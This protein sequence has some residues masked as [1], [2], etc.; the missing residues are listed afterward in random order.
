LRR[1]RDMKRSLTVT[2]LVLA[3]LLLVPLAVSVATH[4][5][6]AVP[7]YQASMAGTGLAPDPA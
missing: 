4:T 7:W 5:S 3:A 2:L 1:F 6:S